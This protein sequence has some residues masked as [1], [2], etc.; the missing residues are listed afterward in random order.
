MFIE[1]GKPLV[2]GKLSESD[3]PRGLDRN[4][5]PVHNR[6]PGCGVAGRKL[7][8]EGQ[9]THRGVMQ[10]LFPRQERAVT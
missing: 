9:V 5:N 7:G 3:G 6:C 8:V 2:C 1:A 4:N 10:G